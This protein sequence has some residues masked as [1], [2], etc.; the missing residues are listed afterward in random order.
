MI[1]MTTKK[2]LVNG[3]QILCLAFGTCTV[4]RKPYAGYTVG[5]VEKALRNGFRLIDTATCYEN[6][7]EVGQAMRESGIAREDIFVLTKMWND[8]MRQGTQREAIEYSLKE[9]DTDYVDAYLLHWPVPGKYIESWKYMEEFYEKGMARSI[10]VSNFEIDQLESLFA[11][12]RIKPMIN[13]IEVHPYNTRKELI[14][15]CKENDIAVMAWS[16]LHRGLIL[17]DPVLET[18]A[19]K[20]GKTTAQITL[21]WDIQNG[22]IPIPGATDEDLIRQNTQLFDFELVQEEMAAIDALNQNL[23]EGDPH[24]FDW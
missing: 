6:E 9:L 16:P 24:N 13:Q 5:A 19:E 3:V 8:N 10:G 4:E 12:C 11:S 1:D 23:Y 21:R 14:H 22:V 20:Y 2:P 15:F 17:N 18:I 7:G